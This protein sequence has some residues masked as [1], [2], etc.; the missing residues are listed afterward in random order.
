MMGYPAL[1]AKVLAINRL[2]AL[3]V[4]P[5]AY[6]YLLEDYDKPIKPRRGIAVGGVSVVDVAERSAS[7]FL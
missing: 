7:F 4:F 2:L 5:A 3:F 1:G 6:M